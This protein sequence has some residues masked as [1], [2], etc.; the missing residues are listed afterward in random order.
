[1]GRYLIRRLVLIIPTLIGLSILTFA[2]SHLVPADPAKLAAGPRATPDM[3]QTIRHEYG[4][5]QPIYIQY[6]RYVRNLFT[7]NWGSSIVTQHTVASELRRYFPAT[8]ELVLASMIF[9]IGL[10]IPLG[11]LAAVY[12]N[13]W[14]DHI[15]RVFTISFVSIPR[16]WFAIILQ[17]T[18]AFSLGWLPLSGRLPTLTSPPKTITGM[19]TLD[20][21]LVG[22][23][24]LFGV[25]LEHLIMPAFVQ[26]IGALAVV[27]RMVRGDML[28]ILGQDFVRTA[29]AKGLSERKV[30]IDHALRN[31]FIPTLTMIGLSFGF[32][33]GGSVLVET[34]FDW[35]GIGLY[36]VNSATTFDFE[37]IMGVTLLVGSVFILLNLIVD[38]LYGV[39]DPRI[40]VA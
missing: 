32:S 35:P 21:L 29:R 17:L 18:I 26:G 7:G 22:N 16:F 3:V 12:Q 13:R 20:S 8:M 34:I 33:L 31:A 40:R 15:S 37:P 1:M 14:P 4:L 19:Y 10:G 30:V 11:V 23:F 9:A 24:H 6:G 36:A 39:L 28:E 25:A 2:I 27:M 38:I 5:D